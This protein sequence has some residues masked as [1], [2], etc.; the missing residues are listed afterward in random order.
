MPRDPLLSVLRLPFCDTESWFISKTPMSGRLIFLR[1]LP[2]PHTFIP[3]SVH[4]SLIC[5]L[6]HS[7]LTNPLATH[8]GLYQVLG[9]QWKSEH[10]WHLSY[11]RAHPFRRL[12]LQIKITQIKT[13]LQIAIKIIEKKHKDYEDS[14]VTG[15]WR[16]SGKAALRSDSEL[17]IW[18]K[19]RSGQ[20]TPAGRSF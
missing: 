10:T 9:K 8:Q 18:R 2:L 5:S 12:T 15:F 13:E 1:D 14:K 19:S 20:E 16:G 3:P 4:H 17:E 11:R 6:T 7:V